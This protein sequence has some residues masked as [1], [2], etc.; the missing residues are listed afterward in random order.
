MKNYFLKNIIT[1]FT[2]IIL[3]N[4]SAVNAQSS[5]A[6][7]ADAQIQQKA[8]SWVQALNLNDDAKAMRVE[9]VV[10][11][12]LISV[13]DWHNSHP[14]TLVPEGINPVTGNK[15]TQL[16]RQL[17]VSSTIPSSVH[18]SLMTGLRENLNEEQVEA[19]LDKYTVGKVAFTMKGY[20][21]IVPNLTDTERAV[22]MT[23]LKNAREQAIDYKNMKEISAIF[24]IYKTKNEQYLNEHGRNWR[25][26][27]KNYVNKVKAEKAAKDNEGKHA[28]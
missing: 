1:I 13:R 19:I 8:T 5:I 16:D 2:G 25:Q 9:K 4:Y 18:N 7:S 12:H 17:I 15:L 28:N 20:E 10:A 22:I 3:L 6:D 24:D 23:N 27:F 14:Y 11:A 21:A 26:L